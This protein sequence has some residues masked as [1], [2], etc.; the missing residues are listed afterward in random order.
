MQQETAHLLWDMEEFYDPV[1]LAT[2][3]AGLIRMDYPFALL[4]LGI[5]AHAD[6]HTCDDLLI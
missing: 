6:P 2:L 5:L 4:V 1:D 3:S